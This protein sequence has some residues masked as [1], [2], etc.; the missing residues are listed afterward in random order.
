MSLFGTHVYILC[1]V[2][3]TQYLILGIYGCVS[4]GTLDRIDE[5]CPCCLGGK[6]CRNTT[7]SSETVAAA[8]IELHRTLR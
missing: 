6:V 5:E 8:T 3:T 2:Q 7:A 1:I 4:I